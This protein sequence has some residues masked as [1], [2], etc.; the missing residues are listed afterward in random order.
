MNEYLL[1]VTSPRVETVFIDCSITNTGLVALLDNGKLLYGNIKNSA[2]SN[3]GYL[4][5]CNRDTLNV[6]LAFFR[7]RFM[8]DVQVHMFVNLTHAPKVY[9]EGAAYGKANKAYWLGQ[10][11]GTLLSN[12][13][14]A[15]I[16]EIPPKSHKK[17]TTGS[18]NANK[19]NT[20]DAVNILYNLK[21]KDDNIAD[22]ISIMDHVTRGIYRVILVDSKFVK[23]TANAN[24]GN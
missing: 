20:I 9:V 6:A 18:G 4:R 19:Q 12:F 22:A 13:K 10:F 8:D 11:N 14:N 1:T 17:T 21:I 3:K 2:F 7:A 5:R 24:Q 16:I 23:G 15:D